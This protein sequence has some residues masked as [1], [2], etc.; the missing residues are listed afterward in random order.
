LAKVPG[1]EQRFTRPTL[2][3]LDTPLE[4]ELGGYELDR[5]KDASDRLVAALQASS[6][7][8]DVTSTMARGFPEIQIRFDPQRAAQLGLLVSDIAERVVN[9]VRGNVATRYR[10]ADRE[11][12]IRVQAR[13]Q[14]RA[15]LATLRRLVVNPT[16]ERPVPLSAVA[17]VREVTGAAEIRRIDQQRVAVVRANLAYGD[18]NSAVAEVERLLRAQPRPRGIGVD[19]TGQKEE[20]EVSFRSLR[21][22]L[23]LAVFMV[24]LVMASQF[25]SLLH[26]F[27]VLFTIP[28]AAI[29][30]ILSLYLSGSV[31]NVVVLIGL[32][33]LAGIVVNNGIVLI[34]LINRLRGEGQIREAAVLAAGRTRL[35]PIVMTTLTTALGL[36]PLALGLGEGAE[37]RAPMAITVIGGLVMSTLLTLVVLPVVYTLLD[38][39]RMP[40][41][42][43]PG[44]SATSQ[45]P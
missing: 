17:D 16:S 4:V 8:T 9:K 11:I 28:L 18:L 19:I 37:I 15:S 26:P 39:R 44:L 45:P 2:F 43:S 40:Q 35:R 21:L 12:D 23:A 36:L 22:A 42:L 25:E 32:I 5:L 24:Y 1:L 31:I 30:A 29:G 20:M 6:R 33:V 41:D 13:E 7:F 14:D 38:R 27:V 10:L 34:D 3:S